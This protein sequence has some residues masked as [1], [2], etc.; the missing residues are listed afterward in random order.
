M[1]LFKYG[2]LVALNKFECKYDTA[3]RI[4]IYLV[5]KVFEYKKY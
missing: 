3:Q 1:D 5:N 2:R 4:G